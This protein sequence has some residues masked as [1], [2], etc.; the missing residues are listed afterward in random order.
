MEKT[1]VAIIGAGIAGLTAAIYLKRSKCDFILISNGEIGGKLNDLKII[2]NFPAYPK[3][4][5]QEL[6]SLL[7]DQINNLDIQIKKENVQNILMDK[8]GF[9]II[10]D[11]RKII[12]KKV[13]IATGISN[14]ET[15]IKG[16]KEFLGSGVS[17][18]AVCDANFFRNK[19]VAVIGNNDVA[20]EESIYL[21]NVVKNVFLLV[22]SK[23]TGNSE[24]IS[25]LKKHTNITVMENSDVSEIKGDFLGVNEIIVN[26]KTLQVSGVFPYNGMKNTTQILS[27]LKP[28]MVN[29][30]INV[31]ENM[32]TNIKG[33]Y[34][35]GDA[36]NKKLKQLITASSDGAI[37]A[38]NISKEIM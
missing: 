12:A 16:E 17:Y 2:E 36:I 9:E 24:L 11:H 22:P 8:E 33:L 29:N 21:S 26:N 23:L 14:S 15:S 27:N 7:V 35:V 3:I 38:V 5:G 10:T 1:K 37:A 25:T 6:S 28:L 32:E 4:S 18:C 19:D 34:A 20:I 30:L 13:I 31:D